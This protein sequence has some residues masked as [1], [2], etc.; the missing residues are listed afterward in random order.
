MYSYSCLGLLLEKVLPVTWDNSSLEKNVLFK[1]VI[2]QLL[3][4]AEMN[5][6]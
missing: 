4:T 2:N 1:Y 6:Y 5:T 3:Y